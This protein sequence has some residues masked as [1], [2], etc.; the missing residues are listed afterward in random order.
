MRSRRARGAQ[1]DMRNVMFR[2]VVLVSMAL[3]LGTVPRSFAQ[4]IAPTG[5]YKEGLVAGAWT[6]FPKISVGAIYDSNINQSVVDVSSGVGARVV[7]YLSGIYDGG[8]HKATVYGVVD[9]RF[10]DQDQI[11]ATAGFS[12]VYEAMRDL[13]FTFTGNY[14]RQTDVFNSALNYN[15]GAIGPAGPNTNIPIIVNP[16]GTTPGVN[17]IPYNQFTTGA[18]VTK[19]FDQVFVTL[20]GTAFYLAYDHSTDIPPPFQTSNNAASVWVSGRVG[21]NVMPALYI[22]TEGAGVFNRFQ[23]SLFDTNGYRVIGGLGSSDPNSLFRGEIYGGYQ[24]QHQEQQDLTGSDIPTNVGSGVFGGRISYYPTRYWTLVASVDE[25]LGIS[26]TLA[27]SVPQGVPTR[28]TTAILQMNYGLSRTWSVGVRGG[29]TRGEF[30]GISGLDNNGWLA[31][32][33]FNYEIWR[34]LL[35]TLDYQYTTVR[36]D[37]PLS[38]FTRNLVTSGLTYKY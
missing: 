38:D 31:G 22:F 35:L 25:A 28:V 9:A 30:I 14:T 13:I 1:G 26:T 27:P 33:S 15:N 24:F 18:S 16:F 12:H 29:Y 8:I 11:A 19:T 36:S 3:A 10:V 2:R 5:E 21:Y 7:P 20:S 23:N 37:A 34:N 4:E 17:P 32:A 6:L